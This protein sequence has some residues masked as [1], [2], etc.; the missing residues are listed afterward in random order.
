MQRRE[1][2]YNGVRYVT[3]AEYAW[4]DGNLACVMTYLRNGVRMSYAAWT[5][6]R[7]ADKDAGSYA[8]W[9]RRRGGKAA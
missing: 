5:K 8:G 6:A 2:T 1:W 4:R 7:E 9:L 3:V